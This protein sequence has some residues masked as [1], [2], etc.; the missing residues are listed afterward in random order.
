MQDNDKNQMTT[1]VTE[2]S[3][4]ELVEKILYERTGKVIKIDEQAYREEE[5][6]TDERREELIK[7]AGRFIDVYKNKDDP[8]SIK[9]QDEI[10]EVTS[11]IYDLRMRSGSKVELIDVGERPDFVIEI[12]GERIG[13]EHTKIVNDENVA[14]IKNVETVFRV[15]GKLINSEFPD[16]NLLVNAVVKLA[17]VPAKRVML[18]ECM[19]YFRSIAEG[20]EIEPPKYITKRIITQHKLFQIAANEDC[21]EVELDYDRLRRQI[22]GKSQ[23]VDAY[24]A[25]CGLDKISLLMINEGIGCNSNFS[26]NLERL[27][28]MKIGFDKIIIHNQSENTVLIGQLNKRS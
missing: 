21:A 3:S 14:K 17:D 16:C 28:D 18:K 5:R 11:F 24:K 27:P 2:N 12:D 25:T 19:A 9:K 15:C 1:R 20:E 6:R 4:V 8:D 22:E 23:K 7:I 10:A 26:I 13:L